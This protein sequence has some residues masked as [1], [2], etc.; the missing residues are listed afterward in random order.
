MALDLDRHPDEAALLGFSKK[1]RRHQIFGQKVIWGWSEYCDKPAISVGKREN[2]ALVEGSAPAWGRARGKL[3]SR[4]GILTLRDFREGLEE[5]EPASEGFLSGW[6][7]GGGVLIR[8]LATETV[9]SP[10]SQ[11]LLEGISRGW[12]YGEI[13]FS[14]NET[15]Q[16][17]SELL[18]DGPCPG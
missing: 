13:L 12:G 18:E 4:V 2:A 11:S 6:S 1:G 3:G 10:R 15:G 17:V 8:S 9:D 5:A 7:G 14:L 16:E